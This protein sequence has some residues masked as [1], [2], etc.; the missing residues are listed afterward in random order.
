[1]ASPI[2]KKQALKSPCVA[3]C[4]INADLEIC[5]GCGRKLS[6]IA[7]WIRYSDAERDRINL[8]LPARL[9]ALTT[10]TQKG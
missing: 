7:S 6:E 5:E 10:D 2:S 1:L 4:K 3:V 9:A 8:Q